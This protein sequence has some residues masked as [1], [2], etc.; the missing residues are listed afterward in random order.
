MLWLRT[1][2]NDLSFV[3]FLTVRNVSYVLKYE[4]KISSQCHLIA[5]QPNEPCIMAFIGDAPTRSFLKC[6]KG[7]SGYY[8]CERCTIRGTYKN[9]RFVYD[10]GA[11][12]PSLMVKPFFC[13]SCKDDLKNCNDYDY[14][15]TTSDVSDE[16][17][18]EK[19]HRKRKTFGDD[20]ETD[21][22]A[23]AFVFTC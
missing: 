16:E 14:T 6:T 3:Y 15:A 2:I 22:W 7:H 12:D 23:V 8:A 10:W 13:Y 1:C 19:C 20:F 9:G 4:S 17:Q 5:I 18:I 11:D 21:K